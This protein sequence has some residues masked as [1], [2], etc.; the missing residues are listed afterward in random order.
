MG[1]VSLDNGFDD[2]VEDGATDGAAVYLKA[3]DG[4]DDGVLGLEDI[5]SF[6]GCL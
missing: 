2:G 5:F 3:P 6:G 1:R 4:V